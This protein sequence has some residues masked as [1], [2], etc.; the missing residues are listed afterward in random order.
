MHTLVE[1]AEEYW[2]V[3]ATIAAFALTLVVSGTL[4]VA[5]NVAVVRLDRPTMPAAIEAVAHPPAP[6][7]EPLLLPLLTPSS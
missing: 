7:S 4:S 6:A 2:D 1:W 5:Y 3:L